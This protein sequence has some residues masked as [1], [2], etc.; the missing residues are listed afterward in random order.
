M[1]TSN[2]E[3]KVVVITGANSG[4]RESAARLLAGNGAKVVLG[5]R[6]KDR[7]DVVV[8]EIIAKGGSAL[9]FNTDV[10][11]RGVRLCDSAPHKPKSAIRG[12]IQRLA[13]A[14]LACTLVIGS[15]G[16]A[17]ASEARDDSSVRALGDTFATAF[18]Q[19]N[20]EL[21]ASVFDKGGSFVTPQG[22]F[23]QGRVAMVKDFGPE[24]QQAVNGRTQAAFSNY[25]I[26]LIKPDVAV[27]DALLT[28]RNVNGP[29]GTII[30]V[31][32]I[33]FFYV[34][35]RHPDKWLIQIG[36]AHFAAAP[37][38]GMTRREQARAK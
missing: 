36:R 7:I 19:K 28:L 29:H 2:I 9:G 22:D 18:V 5:A 34:A 8:T 37:P 35:V 23:L 17:S 25:R 21:R 12:L 6:R 38:S 15:T 33:N 27:V 1:G 16:Y 32:P 3:G 10:T 31:I 11:K 20:A 14:F 24:A 4:I 26:R 13:F 30:P